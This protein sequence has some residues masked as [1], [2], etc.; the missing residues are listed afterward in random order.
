M[1]RTLILTLC[2]AILAVSSCKKKDEI[3]VII[4]PPVPAPCQMIK[5]NLSSN[6]FQLSDVLT[7]D[8]KGRVVKTLSSDKNEVTYAYSSTNITQ[9]LGKSQTFNINYVLDDK[10]RVGQ[11]NISETDKIV[12]VYNTDGYLSEVKDIGKQGENYSMVYSYTNGNLTKIEK[13]G[14]TPDPTS[15]INISYGAD[16]AV[17]NFF[18]PS[19]SDLPESMT[20][21]LSRYFGKP[22]KNLP[23]KITRTLPGRSLIFSYEK[24]A[25]GN[26]IKF[27]NTTS[28]PY[29]S[30]SFTSTAEYSCK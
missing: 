25:K 16:I 20:G 14:G 4:D 22:S 11:E 23:T 1:K 6:L 8:D 3:I 9:T 10:G 26:V 30:Q 29:E 13:K 2:S 15:T 12:Y 21:V 7:Y 24:D 18:I 17:S 19:I 28:A 5:T 27:T